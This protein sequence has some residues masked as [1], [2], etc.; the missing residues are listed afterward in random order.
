M[1]LPSGGPPPAPH[2]CEVIVTV[3]AAAGAVALG[4]LR[5]GGGWMWAATIL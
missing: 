1:V 2:F 4:L 5:N 3:T